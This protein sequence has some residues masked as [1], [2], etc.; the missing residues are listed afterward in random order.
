MCPPEPITEC[1][2]GRY[3]TYSGFCNNVEKPTRGSAFQPMQRIV[4]SDYEDEISRPRVSRD[5]TPL[6][7]SRLVASRAFTPPSGQRPEDPH[8]TVA[9]MLAE[10]AEFVYRDMVHLSS[11]RGKC[12]E[13][14][15]VIL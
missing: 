4:D 9:L 3:R 14:L 12:S 13:F 7:N 8:K 6:P 1:V 15:A 5:K 11:A 2:P 10:W